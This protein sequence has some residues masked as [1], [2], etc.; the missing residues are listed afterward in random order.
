MDD[1]VPESVHTGTTGAGQV[2][3]M[4]PVKQKQINEEL[5]T[6]GPFYRRSSVFR[7][8]KQR[9]AAIVKD[10]EPGTTGA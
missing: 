10:R 7:Q 4:R 1:H 6:A 9:S 3:K 5:N 8:I 2:R